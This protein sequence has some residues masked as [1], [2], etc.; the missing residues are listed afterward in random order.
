MKVYLNE[1]Y[2]ARRASVGKWASLL[3]LVILGIG[4]V[5]SLRVPN[6]FISFGSLAV[7][8]IL[9]NVGIYYANRYTRVDR[10][11]VELSKALKGFDDRYA[12]YQ[13]LLPASQVL[14]EP[15][16][17]T[18]FVLKPQEGVVAFQD[19]KWRNKMGWGR[20]LRWVGQE[21]LG[22]PDRELK[23]EVG[24][25]KDWLQEQAPD[26][27]VPVRGV[28]VFNRAQLALD[29]PPVP[30]MAPKQIKGWLRKAGK[31]PPLPKKTFSRLNQALDEAIQ[32][33]EEQEGD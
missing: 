29:D 32:V 19:G 12:L 11:D 6:L 25:L 15:G 21:G 30:A 2:V 8:F 20:L 7:G 31:L 18:I 27:D 17:L 24:A 33:E 13:F 14:R 3:G 5:V 9:S 1:T 23:Q 10:P 26:L 28:L 22:S 16:G 4:F